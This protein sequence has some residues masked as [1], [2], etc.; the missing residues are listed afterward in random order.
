MKMHRLSFEIRSLIAASLLLPCYGYALPQGGSV[1]AGQASIQS[2]KND[3]LTINQR[4]DRAVINWNSFN[5]ASNEQLNISQPTDQSALLNRVTGNQLSTI[6]GSIHANGQV[7]LVN[8]NGMTFSDGAVVQVGALVVSTAGISNDAFMQG[9]TLVFDQAG[10][11]NAQITTQ[12]GAYLEATQAQNGMVALIA[13]RIQHGGFITAKLGRIQL[14]AADLFSLTVDGGLLNVLLSPQ[15][16]GNLGISI[17]QSG[18]IISQGGLINIQAARLN[19]VLQGL[20]QNQGKIIASEFTVDPT[21]GNITLTAPKGQIAIAGQQIRSSGTLQGESIALTADQALAISKGSLDAT[22]NISLETQHELTL[23]SSAQVISHGGA[24]RAQSAQGQA[25]VAAN[26]QSGAGIT[27][28]AQDDLNI[29]GQLTAAT[30]DIQLTGANSKLTGTVLA[31]TGAIH[32]TAKTLDL[33]SAA[34]AGTDINLTTQDDL[35]QRSS[36]QLRADGA[37]SLNST[38]GDLLLAGQSQAA[39]DVSLLAQQGNL[40]VQRGANGFGGIQSTAGGISGQAQ[41]MSIDG[42]LIAQGGSV[43]LQAKQLTVNGQ[44]Y[45]TT[46]VN[47]DA[48]QSILQNNDSQIISAG[49]L[50]VHSAN[51]SLNLSGINQATGDITLSAE[52]GNIDLQAGANQRGSIWSLEGG[53][54]LST[55]T[56]NVAS[57][58]VAGGGDLSIDANSITL[59]GLLKGQTTVALSAEQSIN[60][61]NNSI[62]LS[63]GNLN[64]TAKQGALNLSGKTQAVGDITLLAQQGALN[65]QQGAD[66]QGIVRSSQ[67]GIRSQSKIANI[68][69]NLLAEGGVLSVQADAIELTGNA[70]GTGVQLHASQNI[71]QSNNSNLISGAALEIQSD[72]GNLTLAGKNQAVGD[73]A[74]IAQQGSINTQAGVDGLGGIKSSQGGMT[75]QTKIANLGGALLANGQDLAINAD[76]IELTGNLQSA[77]DLQLQSTYSINQAN[78]SNINAGGAMAISSAQGNLT[79]AGKNQAVGDIIL[80]A[81]QGS[82]NL[83]AGADGLGG[84]QSSN[85]GIRVK[86]KAANISGALLA[87]GQAL[88]IQADALELSGNLQG[89]TGVQIHTAYQLNQSNSSSLLS[90][91]TLGLTSDQSNINLS[92]KNQA[93][94]DINI[95]AKQGTIST[96]AGTD[97]LGGTHSLNGGMT[98]QAKTAKLGGILRADGDALTVTA[99][100]LQMNGEL[101]GKGINITAQ[102]N[103]SQA[104]S[105]KMLSDGNLSL[106]VSQGSIDLAGQNSADTDIDVTANQGRLTLDGM[107]Q[108]QRGDITLRAQGDINQNACGT[109]AAADCKNTLLSERGRLD[110]HSTQG[111]L[112]LGY[113][114][115]W[116]GIDA[117]A[118]QGSIYFNRAIGGDQTG[119]I[120]PFASNPTAAMANLGDF[121]GYQANARPNTGYLRANAK[122]DIVVN[123]LNLDG[124]SD[125]LGL[126]LVADRYIVS[127]DVI[128]V[129]KGDL[130]FGDLS[131]QNAKVFLGNSVYS[132]G[133]HGALLSTDPADHQL[134]NIR[135][136]NDLVLFDNTNQFLTKTNQTSVSSNQTANGS[137]SSTTQK[138]ANIIISNNSSNYGSINEFSTPIDL[139]PT[140]NG[141]VIIEKS[142]NGLVRADSNTALSNDFLST[143]NTYSI[144][145]QSQASQTTADDNSAGIYLQLISNQTPQL[146]GVNLTDENSVTSNINTEHT[147]ATNLL[148]Q[149]DGLINRSEQTTTTTV[150]DTCLTQTPTPICNDDPKVIT[151]TTNSQTSVGGGSGGSNAQNTTFPPVNGSTVTIGTVVPVISPVVVTVG[152][153]NSEIP[154]VTPIEFTTGT[155]VIGSTLTPETVGTQ[156]ITPPQIVISL[157]N[158]DRIV[159]GGNT[160]NPDGGTGGNTGGNSNGGNNGGTPTGGSSP[161]INIPIDVVVS[162]TLPTPLAAQ[163][164][165][166]PSQLTPCEQIGRS[167]PSIT[168]FGRIKPTT[169]AANQTQMQQYPVMLIDGA[170]TDSSTS[171]QPQN[172]CAFASSEA[173]EALGASIAP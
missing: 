136:N 103:I 82:L 119:Y 38:T 36:S 161:S 6:A 32:V 18:V 45:A 163:L 155:P 75:V 101:K 115:A 55:Q 173:V 60:Q 108:S 171:A 3:T 47:L 57:T 99:N 43:A 104:A 61:S 127:N 112:N 170:G 143:P 77:N 89:A 64:L 96:Q 145:G 73:V 33:A 106:D 52:Q 124:S 147:Q 13:P 121:S 84:S 107:L 116:Q 95:N 134:F 80:S 63:D 98:M 118:D 154:A 130:V 79:L 25:T 85:G 167:I 50:H 66:G 111:N 126:S 165:Q 54:S 123:G 125:G 94:G 42:A 144:T 152:D 131:K 65:V 40:H 39:G 8:P 74:L 67:G 122:Q 110:V 29:S 10:Q 81:Q 172:G 51:G 19:N 105:S 56:A 87:Q 153:I 62:L 31:Q 14:A 158:I 146:N 92:G 97:G 28:L 30:G 150:V 37:L 133:L 91:G 76:T 69:T 9:G 21:T 159:T 83:Q 4:S 169:G 149:V 138:N 166:Q 12:A 109:S 140:M 129:N 120:D 68:N 139:T 41:D 113:L 24:V 16:L 90:G 23:D 151:T 78:S 162:Q 148:I 2:P 5:L 35:T 48:D 7:F 1:V 53:V 27:I 142:I 168:D 44:L 26:V 128:A 20:I 93:A 22:G 17:E 49:D 100:D 86:G 114:K 102:N 70:K 58:V 157:P 46:A 34:Q 132:R 11:S 88:D 71:N 141:Q 160:P 15:D 59:N 164:A 135:I 137:I 72:N 156:I 117:T